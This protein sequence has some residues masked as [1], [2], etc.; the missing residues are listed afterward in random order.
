[1]RVY[2]DLVTLLV[3]S[4]NTRIWAWMLVRS[5]QIGIHGFLTRFVVD[6]RSFG[7]IWQVS[8]RGF[9]GADLIILPCLATGISTFDD[10]PTVHRSLNLVTV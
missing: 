9:F 5:D 8:L 3:S 10:R 4:N 6:C 7:W 1:M 2:I